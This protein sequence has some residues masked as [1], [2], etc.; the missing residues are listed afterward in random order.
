MQQENFRNL[1][2]VKNH[3]KY[4]EPQVNTFWYRFPA[5]K[6]YTLDYLMKS[7]PIPGNQSSF[8]ILQLFDI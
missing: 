8:E 2:R 1:T 6:L 4:L 5:I 3:W 7:A